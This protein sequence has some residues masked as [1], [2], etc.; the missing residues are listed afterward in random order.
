MPE[1]KDTREAT[2]K[3]EA[4]SSPKTPSSSASTSASTHHITLVVV[5]FRVRAEQILVRRADSDEL[6]AYYLYPV[7]HWEKTKTVEVTAGELA[8]LSQPENHLND[9]RNLVPTATDWQKEAWKVGLTGAPMSSRDFQ[10]ACEQLAQRMIVRANT[11]RHLF[12]G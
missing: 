1:K 5:D 9:W 11:I 6:D 3:V 2:P 8:L 10:H 7:K 12:E 4:T